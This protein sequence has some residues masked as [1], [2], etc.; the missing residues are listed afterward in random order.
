MV[1][2]VDRVDRVDK[3][4]TVVVRYIQAYTSYCLNILPLHLHSKIFL[5]HCS[6]PIYNMLPEQ[7]PLLDQH[8]KI[9]LVQLPYL[10]ILLI[11]TTRCVLAYK[12][13]IT[14]SYILVYPYNPTPY[15]YLV[16]HSF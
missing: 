14:L 10:L 3:V 4:D 9:S 15:I 8:N 5:H 12:R 2:R 16:N 6:I 13:D 7:L 11:S 1:D